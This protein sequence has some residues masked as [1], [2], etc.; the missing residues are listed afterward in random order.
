MNHEYKKIIPPFF[1][2]LLEQINK[3]NIFSH[4]GVGTPDQYIHYHPTKDGINIYTSEIIKLSHELSHL[5]EIR[6]NNRLVQLDYGIRKYFPTTHAG[7]LQ[8]IAREA[9]T[10]GIQTRLVELAFGSSQ[11]LYQRFAYVIIKPFDKGI[12]KFTT[13]QEVVEWCT[14]ITRTTYNEWSKDRIIEAWKQKSEFINHWLETCNTSLSCED[15][16]QSYQA[17]SKWFHT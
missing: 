9:R 15:K 8:A 14:N 6:D 4:D 17:N 7:Q 10:R 11:L 2:T 13:S 16:L 12:G 1:Q 3:I 5:L